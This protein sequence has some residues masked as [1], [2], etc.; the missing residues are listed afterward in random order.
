M[1]YY[2]DSEVLT[3]PRGKTYVLRNDK[4]VYVFTECEIIDD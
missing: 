1:S 3:T 2:E 4:K